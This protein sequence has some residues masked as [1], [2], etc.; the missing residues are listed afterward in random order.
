[1]QT[2]TTGELARQTDENV[3]TLRYYERRGL[4]PAPSRRASGYRQYGPGDVARVRAIRRAQQLGFTLREILELLPIL[5]G[6]QPA[7][8]P[9]RRHAEQKLRQ[10]ASRIQQLG[11]AKGSL[12]QLIERC[13]RQPEP[14]SRCELAAALMVVTD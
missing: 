2:M 9:L 5:S 10:L 8:A 13:A 14:K 12:E 3:E 4:L 7:C 11:Q 6:P 1:M